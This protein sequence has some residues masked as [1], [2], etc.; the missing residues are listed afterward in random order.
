MKQGVLEAQSE[1]RLQNTASNEPQTSLLGAQRAAPARATFPWCF[2]EQGHVGQ[3]VVRV[4]LKVL[5]K[6]CPSH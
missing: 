5:A 4:K 1:S 2:F 6:R 3:P